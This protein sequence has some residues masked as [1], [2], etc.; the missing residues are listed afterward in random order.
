MVDN[1]KWKTFQI[2]LILLMVTLSFCISIKMHVPGII[3]SNLFFAAMS[4]GLNMV[5]E[6]MQLGQI[7]EGC[8]SSGQSSCANHFQTE[9]QDQI[10]SKAFPFPKNEKED[11][12]TSMSLIPQTC[13][14][15]SSSALVIIILVSEESNTALSKYSD[16]TAKRQV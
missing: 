9:V 2:E 5:I 3:I 8:K 6:E 13:G 15:Q 10:L 11:G 4:L 14:P 1:A 12:S 7:L 16:Q